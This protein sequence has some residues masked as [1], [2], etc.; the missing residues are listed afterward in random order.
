[1]YYSLMR[2]LMSSEER[3]NTVIDLSTKSSHDKV[4]PHRSVPPYKASSHLLV[5]LIIVIKK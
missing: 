4:E 2:P 3:E 1:M 5:I